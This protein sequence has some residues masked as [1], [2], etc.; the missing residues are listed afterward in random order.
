VDDRCSPQ[1]WIV[2]GGAGWVDVVPGRRDLPRALPD[3]ASLSLVEL[4]ADAP[5]PEGDGFLFRRTSRPGQGRLTGRPTIGLSIVL[6]TPRHDTDEAARA[7]RDWGDFVHLNHIAAAAVPGYTMIT[8]YEIVGE[9]PRYLHLYEMDTDDPEAAFQAMTPL[10]RERLDPDAFE[11]WAWHPELR[12][13]Y[14]SSFRR[15]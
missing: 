12:I 11:A 3:M 10:V 4:D 13:D 6:I 7:L 15:A 5:R 8:P 9:G 2:P 1:L 14:V